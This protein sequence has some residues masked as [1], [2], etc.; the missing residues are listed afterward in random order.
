MKLIV[1][2]GNPGKKYE[3]TRHNVGFMFV[4][5]MANYYNTSFSKK[6][7]YEIAEL[8]ISG[9]KVLLLKPLTFMNL[10][11]EAVNSV[12]NFY[13]LEAADIIVIYDDLD[14]LFGKLRAKDNSSSG[15]HNGIKNII[16]HLH[17][18]QFMRIKIGINN[19]YKKDVKSFVLSKFSKNEI[20]ELEVLYSNIITGCQLFISGA[21]VQKVQGALIK[22][23]I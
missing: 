20:N 5:Y 12:V 6:G 4:D 3:N 22:W 8:N 10:S 2:L 14:M 21:E 23:K 13:K 19:E 15:G 11:G 7:N 1:G 17:T 18:Q 9:E 16:S